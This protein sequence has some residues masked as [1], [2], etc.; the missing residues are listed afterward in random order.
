MK[1]LAQAYDTIVQLQTQLVAIKPSPNLACQLAHKYTT[2]DQLSRHL[3]LK[4]PKL[5]TS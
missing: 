4:S 1:Q 5:K 2:F 3:S